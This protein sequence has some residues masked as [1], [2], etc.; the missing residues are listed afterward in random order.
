M[1]L[2]V[3]NDNPKHVMILP[4]TGK[5][6]K[7]RPYLIK[8]EKILLMAAQQQDVGSMMEA[9]IDTIESCVDMELDRNNLTTFDIE[10]MFLKIRSKSVG[11][12]A[13]IGLKCSS[14]EHTN[15]V[16]INLEN[17]ECSKGADNKTI[18]L[19]DQITLE[20]QYPSY[21]S[22]VLSED[23]TELGFE[24]IASC[25]KTVLTEDERFEVGD[26]S[27][28]EIRGFLESMTKD[29]FERVGAFVETMP[30]LTENVTY[31]CE[32]CGTVN[33][34]EIKGLQSFF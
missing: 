5:K 14:C 1:A 23:E 6:V 28:E 17:V 25:I 31:T 2:P 11:E 12:I 10:Y 33:Q 19:T 7:F 21:S 20:M 30:Q 27:K 16:P 13:E 22:I 32:K 8:E 3:L 24:I 4:S 15:I 26:E 34:L 29:Q 18:E 9:V